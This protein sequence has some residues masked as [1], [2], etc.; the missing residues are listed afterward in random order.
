M[1][2]QL[3]GA[4]PQHDRSCLVANFDG[5]S[6]FCLL[7]VSG[8]YIRA[9]TIGGALDF[10]KGNSDLGNGGRRRKVFVLERDHHS[11]AR[12][13]FHP[14]E[15]QIVPLGIASCCMRRCREAL[16]RL[17]SLRQDRNLTPT[18]RLGKELSGNIPNPDRRYNYQHVHSML[19]R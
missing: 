15:R 16:Y 1:N 17:R 6:D 7:C 4:L 5:N 18:A 19:K 13:H 11:R 12:R 9:A 10:L 8:G 14:R 3:K 2:E